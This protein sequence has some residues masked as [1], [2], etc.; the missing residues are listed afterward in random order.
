MQKK[1]LI[2][3]L[4]TICLTSCGSYPREAMQIKNFKKEYTGLDTLIRIDGYYYYE[5]YVGL[6]LRI[7]LFAFSKDGEF[8]RFNAF[9]THKELQSTLNDPKFWRGEYGNYTIVGDTIKAKLTRRFQIISYDLFEEYFI[10]ENDTTLSRI[11][12]L[13][14]F[15]PRDRRDIEK[16]EIVRFREYAF[17]LQSSGFSR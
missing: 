3:A 8:K 4:M 1:Y 15:N 17:G 10:I 5:Y 2:F 12:A 11:R 7:T 14:T 16:N 6:E 9:D 13:M